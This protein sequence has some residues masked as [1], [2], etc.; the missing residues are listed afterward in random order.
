MDSK[1]LFATL[2]TCRN[3]AD[4]S[5]RGDVSVIRYEFETRNV[6]RMIWIPGSANYADPLTKTDSPISQALELMF[7]DGKISMDFHGALFR[8]SD[9]PTG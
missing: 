1:D 6:D 2:S 4:R 9:A 7:F 8:N 3:V 5:I